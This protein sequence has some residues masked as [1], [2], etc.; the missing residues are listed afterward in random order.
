[1]TDSYENKLVTAARL[2]ARS[3]HLVAFTGA[4]I[5]TPSGIPDFRSLGTGLWEENDPMLVASASAFRNEP[6]RF[7]NWL[8]PLLHTAQ[9]ALPNAAHLALAGLENAGILKAV[10][11]Q[12]ID[13]LHQ[14]AG[15]RTVIEL[16]G[17]MKRFYC[18]SCKND[19]IDSIEAI[20]SVLAESIPTCNRCGAIVRPDITLFEEALPALAWQLAESEI[21]KADLLLVAGSSLEVY[22]ASLLPRE[23]VRNG[24]RIIIVNYTSTLIDGHA[25]VVMQ[26]DVAIA[27]PAIVE[28]LKSL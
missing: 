15:A 20:Y 19:E 6:K 9:Q 8:R 4:G 26:S 17:S 7:Y 25:D 28:K 23:A 1:M 11:T 12:N 27:I 10:I 14:K 16:H 22:P 24:C 3:Q 2:I 5:S 18:P 13:E 21:S